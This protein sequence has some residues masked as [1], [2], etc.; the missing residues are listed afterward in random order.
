MRARIAELAARLAQ[1][2]PRARLRRRH[3]AGLRD[4]GQDR[5]RGPLRL[6]RDRHGHQPRRA[7]VR[8]GGR[9]PDPDQP[10]RA[11][12]GRD[13]SRPS[14]SASSP[15]RASPARSRRI[16]SCARWGA[17]HGA[18]RA[19]MRRMTGFGKQGSLCGIDRHRP[20]T[21][22]VT[23]YGSRGRRWRM[24]RGAG[25]LE[26]LEAGPVICAEGYLFELE[27][28][29]YLQAGAS[30]PEVVLDHPERCASSIA[31]SCTPAPTWSRPSPITR[32]ARSC[33]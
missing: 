17:E 24:R 12:G 3:R 28:R 33:G 15:S 19:G 21:S 25:R 9:R 10:A 5:L 30:C 13:R 14:R 2:R 1:A 20:R 7:P 31:S 8:R 11:G 27:R 23:L 6:R 22:V 29:G 18:C 32:T 4:A 26:R 16:A